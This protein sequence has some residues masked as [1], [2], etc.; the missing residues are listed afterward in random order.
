MGCAFRKA[1]AT[2][3]A[4]QNYQRLPTLARPILPKPGLLAR[5]I[6]LSRAPV[7]KRTLLRTLPEFSK[8][9]PCLAAIP[10]ALGAARVPTNA[11]GFRAQTLRC[12]LTAEGRTFLDFADVIIV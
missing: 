2:R 9:D 11:R 8:P 3:A 10:S 4:P 12:A 7:R 5:A 6:T 1:A